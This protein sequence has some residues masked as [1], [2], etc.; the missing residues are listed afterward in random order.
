MKSISIIKKNFKLLVR[1]KS[2]AFIIL[3]GPLLIILLVGLVFSGKS[4]YEL[5]IGYFAPEKNNLTD[6][7]IQ[8]LQ[9]SNYYLH[10]YP[11]E[12][13]CIQKI[14]QG[15]IHTCIIFPIDFQVS[16]QQGQELKFL[17][18]YSR[19]SLVYE[20]I[21]SVSELLEI[22]SE[23]LSY[24]MTQ[25]LLD[26][27]NL[28]L[29]EIR[30]DKSL[31][32]G[33]SQKASLVLLELQKAKD[34]AASLDLE[35]RN[36]STQDMNASLIEMNSTFGNISIKGI[37]LVNMSQELI[38]ELSDYLDANETSELQQEFDELE[39]ELSELYYNQ[40]PDSIDRL[41]TRIDAISSSLSELESSMVI[42]EGLKK[43][44]LQR[45]DSSRSNLTSMQKT[46]ADLKSSLSRSQL[47]LEAITITNAQAIVSPVNVKIEPVAAESSRALFA[48]PSLLLLVIMFVALLL[49]STL[50]LFEKS[51]KASFRVS[52]TPTKPSLFIFTTFMTSLLILLLQ[53][54]ILLGLASHFLHIPL[55][56][57]PLTSFL[58][59]LSSSM[60][61]I[62]LGMLIG[63]VLSTQEGA[64]MSSI[65]M[66]SILLF[67]SNLV[68]P[69][70]SI[71]PAL[72]GIIKYNPYV[73][74]SEL[75]RKSLLFNTELSGGNLAIIMML[76]GAALVL[77][78]LI[79]T[80]SAF[81]GRKRIRILASIAEESPKGY[82]STK[83]EGASRVTEKNKSKSRQLILEFEVYGKKAATKEEL[84]N[85][86]SDM[87]KTEFEENVNE[88]ENNIAVWLEKALGEKKLASKLRK[89]NSR[90]E[91]L[92]ILAKD[93]KSSQTRETRDNSEL[94]EN[95]DG[96]KWG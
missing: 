20:V 46:L 8:A 62:T 6:S 93:L 16:N 11:A 43:G 10:E 77:L 83:D 73:M 25:L 3:L 24:S 7:F 51:S 96:G 40:T 90:E 60:F 91:I 58:I 45:I 92:G 68:F 4:S 49:S 26:K 67:L 36:I 86:V 48:F 41:Y 32:D 2:S 9:K 13:E 22:K 17:V 59:I 95:S 66:G 75:L 88:R 53:T 71:A 63:Y 30:N 81:K 72:V 50:V 18:D 35:L 47:E 74:S 94:G 33:L 70:E 19:I 14:E 76:F 69:L 23:E 64:V 87:T 29:K 15:I 27:L 28:T 1:S 82:Y 31:V 44:A 65:V 12:Q 80:I 61:F 54:I 5:S 57:N 38:D 78:A 42:N 21:G 56:K 39:E 79:I 55:F 37:E 85:L 34:D 89:T 52:I 84:F